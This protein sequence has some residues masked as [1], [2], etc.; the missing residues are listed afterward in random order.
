M[1]EHKHKPT[2]LDGRPFAC[3]S[4]RPDG[5][6]LW[7]HLCV[8]VECKQPFVIEAEGASLVNAVEIYASQEIGT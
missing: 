7:V 8:C 4:H 1:K 2:T 3:I 6:K 5:A